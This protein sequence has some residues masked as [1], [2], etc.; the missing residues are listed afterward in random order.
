MADADG[1]PIRRFLGRLAGLI[2]SGG[3]GQDNPPP[4]ID[5]RRDTGIDHERAVLNAQMVMPP[6]GGHGTTS[7]R[8]VDPPKPED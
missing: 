7:F 8:P 6:S 5:G 1:G 4:D 2:P 3:I